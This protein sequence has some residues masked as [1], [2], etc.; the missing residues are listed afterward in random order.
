MRDFK[1]TL[2]RKQKIDL[3]NYTRYEGVVYPTKDFLALLHGQGF[4][5]ESGEKNLYTT[6]RNDNGNRFDLNAAEAKY[7]NA[8]HQGKSQIVSTGQN[9]Y[10]IA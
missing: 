6:N 1:L 3:E 10:V 5:I 8:L 4:F 2:T 7:L 9:S